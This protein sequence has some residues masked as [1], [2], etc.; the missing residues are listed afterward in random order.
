MSDIKTLN[1]NLRK[2]L[3]GGKVVLTQG[4]QA[5]TYEEVAEIMLKV[6]HFDNFTKA[7]DPYLSLIHI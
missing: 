3:I 7:N 2:F 6:R 4:I 5:K 1:D